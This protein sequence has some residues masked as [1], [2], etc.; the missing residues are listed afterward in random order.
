MEALAVENEVGA[1]YFLFVQA[2]I[3]SY[4]IILKG[5]RGPL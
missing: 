5:P 3:C 1:N 4:S 2:L